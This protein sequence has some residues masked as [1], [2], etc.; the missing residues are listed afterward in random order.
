[1]KKRMLMA[2]GL[3]L[4]L[5]LSAAGCGKKKEEP[6]TQPMTVES[7][8]ET[9]SETSEVLPEGK[10]RSYLTGEVISS[11][12]GLKR[13]YA[14]MINNIKDSF[15]QSGISDAEMIYECKVE[16]GI[17]RLMAVFQD[18]YKAKKI[19]SIR[20]ARHYYIDLANDNDAIY[21][22]FGQS[23]YAKARIEKEKIKTI[24]GLSSYGGKVFYRTKD[25]VAPH[26]V[27]TNAKM[28]KE[29]LKAT[30][31]SRKYPEGY[32]A[33]FKF[34]KEDTPLAQGKTAEK[35]NIPFD[36]N[37]YFVYDKSTGL[38]NRFQYGQKHIDTE[39]NKQIAVK[40]IF[41][42][43]VREKKI[44]SHDHQ[45]LKLKGTGSGLYITDGK[46]IKVKWVKEKES[47]RT[48][49]YDESG[50]EVVLNPGKTFFEEVPKK[51]VVTFGDEAP[52][53]DKTKTASETVKK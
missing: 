11:K 46:A 34:N 21:V 49:F 40:N 41:V 2:A 45:D 48:L 28:L 33:R 19:G 18:V 8:V 37:P 50:S 1:M 35:V 9:S 53:K 26:N 16:G 24:S 14:I 10:M 20:S 51:S 6:K 23:K 15:P 25:R 31:I 5:V 30:G 17:T 47:D 12:V 13:P 38:Y 39:N 36:S 42:Q 3:A 32:T 4:A 22:H 52:I 7:T 43:Y 44:S 29:G 27:F